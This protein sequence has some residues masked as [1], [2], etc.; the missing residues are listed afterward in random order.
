MLITNIQDVNNGTVFYVESDGEPTI[1]EITAVEP[2]V[3]PWNEIEYFKILF[4]R[5]EMQVLSHD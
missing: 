3:N 2:Y 5:S 1:Y 4:N